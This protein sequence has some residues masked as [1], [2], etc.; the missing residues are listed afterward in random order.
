M[1]KLTRACILMVFV[2]CAVAQA[3]V[4]TVNELL[5]AMGENVR[6]A[7]AEYYAASGT[8][9]QTVFFDDRAL[10]LGHH[11][12]P[13]DPRRGGFYDIAWLS[14]QIEGAASPLTSG[15][16]QAAIS[17]AMNTWDG[18][19]CS[20][21]PL[22]ELSDLGLDW[23]YMQWLMGFGGIPGWYAD[24][25][26]AGWLPGAFFDAVE[27]PDGS[28][29]ILGVTFT[30]IWLDDL[31]DEPTDIDNN[32]KIDVAFRETYY[33][34]DFVWGIDTADPIDVE[35]VVLHETGHGLS[36]GHFGKLIRTDANGK[37][38]FAPRALMN[39]GYTGV[40]QNIKGT[41]LAGHCSIWASWPNN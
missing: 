10:Q 8:V 29:Y 17:D 27:P 1:A 12:V 32:G 18:L 37:F 25:T 38:H 21:I 22:V 9:G 35:T 23:G 11:F 3:S 34:N 19:T 2:S 31:T 24:I 26:H 30:F 36:Q 14:D 39:A 28:A 4:D 7:V 13:G 6:L 16:T 41:D 40:Q 20:T 33:N 5:E 15:E